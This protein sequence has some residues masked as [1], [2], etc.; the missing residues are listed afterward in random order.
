MKALRPVDFDI[1]KLDDKLDLLGGGHQDALEC[2]LDA[3][4]AGIEH[5]HSVSTRTFYPT[6]RPSSLP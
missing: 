4:I 5:I 3:M 6:K 2:T 1:A